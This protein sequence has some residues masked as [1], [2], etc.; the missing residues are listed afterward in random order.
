[1][2][3]LAD[4]TLSWVEGLDLTT[5]T[6]YVLVADAIARA[7]QSG[8][9]NIGD[10]LPPQRDLAWK[11]GCTIGT[12]TRAYAELEKRG[13]AKGE[14]GRGTFITDPAKGAYRP[15]EIDM[16]WHTPT[17]SSVPEQPPFLG[18]LQDARFQD[19]GPDEG[20]A[21]LRHDYPPTGAEVVEAARTMAEIKNPNLLAEMLAYQP[22]AGM[23]RHR[24]TGAK[25]LQ[26]RG[27]DVTAK[28]VVVTSGAHNGV[29]SALAAITRA[30]DVIAV[31]E[32][33]YPGIKAIAGML[34]LKITPVAMDEEGLD[35]DA[36]EKVCKAQNVKALYC[37]PTLQNPVNVTMST[38]RRK[39]IATVA[40]RHN[41]KIIEDDVFG[42]MPEDDPPALYTYLPKGLG[43]YVN[44]V[45]KHLSPGLRVGYVASSGTTIGQVASAIRSCSWMAS[46][47]TTEIASQWIESGAAQ[48]V[49]SAHR[50]EVIERI[51]MVKTT[52]E[53]VEMNCPSGALHAWVQV[54]EL[55]SAAEVVNAAQ[56]QD[57]ILPSTEAFVMGHGPTPRAIRLSFCQPVRRD[58]LQRGLNI[59]QGILSGSTDIDAISVF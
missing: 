36:L 18:P 45:S 59:L 4:D 41:L 46:P 48:R 13:L 58:T 52:L 22:H 42:M 2:T 30:D 17:I 12:I 23:E 1:M 47:F 56:R 39:A 27:L 32:L 9:I 11:L 37:I 38:E 31:E 55:L 49:V 26:E 28:D 3:I 19:E 43:I 57:V 5:G 8:A 29:L 51:K 54:P 21:M 20:P 53:G 10:R 40:A 33:T 34:N 50:Q 35:P 16:I 7:A 24:V 15:R 44:S 25:W 6:K 14:V